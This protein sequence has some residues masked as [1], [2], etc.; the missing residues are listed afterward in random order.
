MGAHCGW[1]QVLPVHE[2]LQQSDALWQLLP[3]LECTH[4]LL[5]PQ[6]LVQQSLFVL[7][8]W[9]GWWQTP[10]AL[11]PVHLPPAQVPLQQSSVDWQASPPWRHLPLGLPPGV[12]GESPEFEP[13]LLCA[14]PAISATTRQAATKHVGANRRRSVTRAT[15]MAVLCQQ[16]SYLVSTGELERKTRGIS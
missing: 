2:P 10:L 13:L 4:I 8:A 16:V 11:A 15:S 12:F 7:H 1:S 14:Q 9:P 3:P 6:L 5:L